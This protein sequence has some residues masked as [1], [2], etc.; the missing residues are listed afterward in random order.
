MKTLPPSWLPLLEA[1]DN[2]LFDLADALG[3]NALTVERWAT[4]AARPRRASLVL[5][6][7]FCATYAVPMPDLAPIVP[8]LP[9][10][11]AHGGLKRVARLL[12]V[13]YCRVVAVARDR[14]RAAWILSALANR[15]SDANCA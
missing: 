2:D 1:V 3:T 10:I 4:G 12:G 13:P 7:A 14:T 6:H 5:L 15:T 8:V 11:Q 9:E